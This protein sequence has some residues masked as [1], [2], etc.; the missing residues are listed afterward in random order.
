MEQPFQPPRVRDIARAESLDETAVRKLLMQAARMGRVYRVAH[1]HYFDRTAVAALADIVRDLAR[2]APDGTVTAAPFRDR[3]GTG[4]KLAIHI[5]EY[6]D[7]V[8]LTRRLRDTHL[9]RNDGLQF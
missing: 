8:G 7:R 6:F 4:R 1:D 9:L 2:E 3:I 5:L